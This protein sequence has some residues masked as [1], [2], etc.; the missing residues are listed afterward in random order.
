MM[1]GVA[2]QSVVN[3]SVTGMSSNP[4]MGAGYKVEAIADLNGDR[5]GDVL[6]R[7]LAGNTEVWMS[8]QGQAYQTGELQLHNNPVTNLATHWQMAGVDDFDGDGKADL[9][10]RLNIPGHTA[11]GQISIWTMDGFKIGDQIF[12]TLSPELA[13]L[14]RESM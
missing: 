3:M 5:K 2:R 9:A 7:D 10:W 11:M 13:N 14:N 6:W 12:Q 1:N 8:Q 4:T